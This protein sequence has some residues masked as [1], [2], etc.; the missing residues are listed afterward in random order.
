MWLTWL[1]KWEAEVMQKL[2]DSLS[3]TLHQNSSVHAVPVNTE[4]WLNTTQK[5]DSNNGT[6]QTTNNGRN[7]V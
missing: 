4:Q 5:E 2:Q 6:N 1:N 7:Q 3:E